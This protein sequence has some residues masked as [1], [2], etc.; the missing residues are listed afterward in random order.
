MTQ[1]NFSTAN[2]TARAAQSYI[3]FRSNDRPLRSGCDKSEDCL[4]ATTHLP[5]CPKLAAEL[6]RWKQR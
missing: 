6:K 4:S 2:R 3:D 1:R 5:G